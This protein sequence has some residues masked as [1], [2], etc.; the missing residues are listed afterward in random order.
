[1][2]NIAERDAINK[3]TNAEIR[4]EMNNNNNISS[5]MDLDG[6]IN[7]LEIKLVEAMA[8]SAEGGHI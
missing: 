4:V 5:E 6:V 8:V 7:L 1:M 3:F 2:R